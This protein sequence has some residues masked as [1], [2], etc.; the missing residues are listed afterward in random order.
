MKM[1]KITFKCVFLLD[2]LKKCRVLLS[3]GHF[4]ERTGPS[5]P[6]SAGHYTS[7]MNIEV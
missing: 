5:A 2:A 3:S 6:M 7:E 4:V 1:L